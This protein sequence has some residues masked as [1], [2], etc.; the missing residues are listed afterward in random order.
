MRVLV[1][2]ALGDARIRSEPL[3]RV[4]VARAMVGLGPVLWRGER[5]R[6]ERERLQVSAQKQRVRSARERGDMPSPGADEFNRNPS[7]TLRLVRIACCWS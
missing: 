2:R 3:L 6:K 5:K 7:E 4:A 1:G